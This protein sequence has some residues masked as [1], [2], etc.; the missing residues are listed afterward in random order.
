MTKIIAEHQVTV[1]P[2]WLFVQCAIRHNFDKSGEPYQHCLHGGYLM[3]V[4]GHFKKMLLFKLYSM[5]LL[6]G[7]CFKL[8]YREKRS[9]GVCLCLVERFLQQQPVIWLELLSVTVA[10]WKAQFTFYFIFTD[11]SASPL[12]KRCYFT[13]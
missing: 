4:R 13:E 5:K 8:S 12:T 3:M 1:L 10:R 7:L 11:L 9:F 2:H 6:I